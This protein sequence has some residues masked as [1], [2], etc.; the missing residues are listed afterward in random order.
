MSMTCLSADRK[1]AASVVVQ[2]NW[3]LVGVVLFHMSSLMMMCY[4][5]GRRLCFI[6]HSGKRLSLGKSRLVSLFLC[7][8]YSVWVCVCVLPPPPFF[9]SCIKY[10]PKRAQD[11]FL[12]AEKN[13]RICSVRFCI[14][15]F[16]HSLQ[17][18]SNK[19]RE[20]LS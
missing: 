6:L 10:Q 17:K 18:R 2:H 12:A 19:K 7:L 3:S 11:T 4:F 8:A 20:L 14:N 16:L 1:L 9:L 15:T 5:L 13:P